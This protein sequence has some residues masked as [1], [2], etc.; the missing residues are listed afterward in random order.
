MGLHCFSPQRPPCYIPS[1][2]GF[3]IGVWLAGIKKVDLYLHMMSQPPWDKH[4]E[5]SPGKPFSIIHYTYGMDYKLTGTGAAV[6]RVLSI[7][8]L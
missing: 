3:T 4:L 5:L 8:T 6:M 7:I 2:Y 1:R